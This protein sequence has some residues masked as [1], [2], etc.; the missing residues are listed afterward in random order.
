MRIFKV[1]DRK[2][3]LDMTLRDRL[4]PDWR[5]MLKPA[6]PRVNNSLPISFL[7]MLS[8]S[9]KEIE[10]IGETLVGKR[11][12]EIG[13]A[14]GERCF[15]MAKYEGTRVHGIDV[16]EY[17]LNQSPDINVWNPEDVEFIKNK[18]TATREKI[19]RKFPESVSK[20]VTFET[21][22]AETYLTPEPYDIII[23]FD[24]LEHIIDLDS[25]F[26][27]M[28]LNVKPGGIV[29]HEYNPFFAI[30][31]GHSLCTLD[32]QYGHCLLS[33]KDFE[34]Y[35]SEIRPDEEDIAVN[36][37]NKCLNRATQKDIDELIKK[38]GFEL[39]LKIIHTP[40][41]PV[42]MIEREITQMLLP[43][44]VKLYPTATVE[45]LLYD[46]IQLVLRKK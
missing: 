30:N 41:S 29:S 10:K 19:A 17:T 16:L 36:F 6:K 4:K 46:S 20:K 28:S 24:V 15:L 38:H 27:Q 14:D 5:E 22:S 31:G 45:D 35:I 33:K 11:I 7:P 34:R 18:I 2:F 25:A 12:L 13:C 21:A 40:F 44:V 1:G 23:S 26:R 9:E 43:T 37:Y 32:F 39:V 42:D 8:K 3:E